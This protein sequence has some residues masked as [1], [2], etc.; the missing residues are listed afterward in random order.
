M[1]DLELLEALWAT[2]TPVDTI[3]TEARHEGPTLTGLQR[4]GDLL[5]VP[6]SVPQVAVLRLLAGVPLDAH[7]LT[8]L[9][10]DHAHQVTGSGR[11]TWA[12]ASGSTSSAALGVLDVPEGSVA[13][14]AH[15][16][17]HA[18]LAIGPGRYVLRRQRAYVPTPNP[19]TPR[20]DRAVQPGPG[21]RAL[22]GRDTAPTW[23]T[24]ID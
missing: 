9:G 11:A 1:N 22:T 6:A 7:P 20:P 8:V 5:L 15:T 2:P 17:H 23:R 18:P 10:G 21:R 16:G 12:P 14:L 19:P 24:V 13:W 4:Q 3:Q